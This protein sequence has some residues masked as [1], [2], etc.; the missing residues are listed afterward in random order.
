MD[1]YSV[2]VS[3]VASIFGTVFT[4]LFG[5]WDIAFMVL[6]AFIALDYVTGVA[7]AYVNKEVSSNIGLKGIAKKSSIFAVLIVAVLL[8]RLLENE[9]WI[10][11]TLVTYF[12]IA[13]EGISILENASGM[14]IKIPKKLN[15]VLLQLRDGYKNTN[16]KDEKSNKD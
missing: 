16:T 14:G 7:K 9:S 2:K 4:W 3:S 15:D 8:D 12:Y 6:V 1:F 10:F 5:T 11:R 13:N